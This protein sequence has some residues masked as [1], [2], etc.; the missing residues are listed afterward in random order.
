MRTNASWRDGTQVDMC[1]AQLYSQEAG[2]IAADP[3]R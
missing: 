1:T 3:G 2:N